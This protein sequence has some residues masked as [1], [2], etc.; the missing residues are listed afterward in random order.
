MMMIAERSKEFGILISVGMR[1][2]KLIFTTIVESFIMSLLGVISG[3]LVSYPILIYMYHHPIQVPGVENNK[4]YD[5]LGIEPIFFFS[6]E[7]AI[8]FAQA[9]VVM[10]ITLFTA[11]YSIV[12]IYRLKPV[13]AMRG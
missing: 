5:S 9:E 1:K 11:I 10:L 8:L 6:K 7:L 3:I 2:S 13:E 4:L 12:H